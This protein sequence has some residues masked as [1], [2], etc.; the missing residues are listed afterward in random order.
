MSV[1]ARKVDSTAAGR[2]KRKPTVQKQRER[3][4]G[5]VWRSTER[6]MFVVETLGGTRKAAKVF[7]V[8]PSQP[9]RWASGQSVPSPLQ[10]R[11]LVDVDHVLALAL[12]LWEPAVARDWLATSNGHLDGATPI[13]AIRANRADEVVAAIRAETAGAY[14]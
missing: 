1:P 9:S 14:V 2:G 11:V 7:E 13:D 5:S 4:D 8:A 6:A 10:A 12:Q 3:S